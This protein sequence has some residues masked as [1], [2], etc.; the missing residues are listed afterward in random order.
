MEIQQ[1]EQLL[2]AQL[3]LAEVYVKAD[4]SHY[5]VTAVGDCFEGLSRVKQQQLVYQ[6]IQAAIA[7]GSIHAIS[8]KTF[9]PTQWRREKLLNPVT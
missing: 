6:P 1:I 2:T 7:E 3:Q 5:A 9:T 4:G 8:I